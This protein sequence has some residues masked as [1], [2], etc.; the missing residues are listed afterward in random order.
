MGYESKV[1]IV[2]SY[3]HAV[4]KNA[5]TEVIA[6]INLSCIEQEI[7]DVFNKEVNFRIYEPTNTDEFYPYDVD[8]YGKELTY[9]TLSELWAVLSKINS[10]NRRIDILKRTL[11]A[12]MLG[13]F[14]NEAIYIVHYG[15]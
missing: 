14:D 13:R 6:S 1:I 7:I 12:I 4:C 8:K 10:D 3:N 9:C 5:L 15:Y 11:E 2:H